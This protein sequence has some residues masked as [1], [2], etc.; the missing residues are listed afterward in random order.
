MLLVTARNSIPAYTNLFKITDCEV[1]IAAE[2]RL[3][4]VDEILAVHSLRVIRAPSI[5]ELLTTSYR[6]YA[7]AKTFDEARDEPLVVMH[8]SGTTALPKPI[9]YTH[10]FAASYNRITQLD[11]PAGFKSL[12][13]TF[14]ANRFFVMMP[15][16]HV[17]AHTAL[18]NSSTLIC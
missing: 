16:F 5:E 9:V 17:S 6:P 2:P 18:C 11:P 7:F 3:P 12:D 14:Q 10:D 13:R 1:M 4:K 8:T 15:P